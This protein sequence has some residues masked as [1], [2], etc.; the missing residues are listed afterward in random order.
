MG[1]EGVGSIGYSDGMFVINGQAMDL[2]QAMMQLNI[3]RTNII[4]SQIADQMTSV[5][6]RNEQMRQM[7][8]AMTQ[9]RQAKIGGGGVVQQPGENFSVTGNEIDLG[10]GYK[11]VVNPN[12][13]GMSHSDWKIVGPNGESTTVWGDPHVREADGGS[14][15]FYGDSTFVLPDGTKISVGTV[16]YGDTQARLSGS[17]TITRGNQCVSVSNVNTESPSISAVTQNGREVDAQTNDGYIFTTVGKR[18][19]DWALDG[20]EVD[21]GATAAEEDVARDPNF[22]NE[23]KVL[24]GPFLADLGIDVVDGDS[25]GLLRTEDADAMVQTLKGQMDALNSDSQLQMTRLQSLMNKRNQEYEQIS[26]TL[27]KDQKT[28]DS[29]T[30]NLR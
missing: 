9:V 25:D 6:E 3:E 15:E 11:V 20:A 23:L 16:P 4:D 17:L 22:K 27:Q 2:G 8:D 24:D 30:G 10:N 19:D 29:I 28:R 13:S 18:A 5:K 14:F 26:N 7:Q 12:Q 21:A 1:A